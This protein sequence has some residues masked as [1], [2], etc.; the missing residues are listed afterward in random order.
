MFETKR[1]ILRPWEEADAE[2]LFEYAKDPR[3]GPRAGWPAHADVDESRRVIREVLS[4]PE[5]YAIVWKDSGQVIGD[6]ALKFHCDL[7]EKDDECELGYWIGVPYWGRGIM[8][9]AAAVLIR[10][11]FEDL[12]MARIW[13]GYYD[14]NLQSRRVQE[15]CG[16]RYQWTTER[17]EVPLMHEVRTGHVSRITREEWLADQHR[18]V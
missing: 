14:D 12:H 15:K 2:A 16:F 13:C 6:V 18:S 3:V 10:H 9:E 4:A 1:L 7:A 8:P 5:N 11:A 17:V